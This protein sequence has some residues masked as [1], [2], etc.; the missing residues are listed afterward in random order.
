VP[1]KI[2]KVTSKN[3]S[4]YSLEVNWSKP[5][6]NFSPINDYTVVW[7][8]VYS[9]E[10][11]ED[12]SPE[13]P[14]NITGLTPCTTYT[15][16]VIGYNYVGN[17]KPSDIVTLTTGKD[18][19]GKS[20]NVNVKNVPPYSLQVD[21]RL[22]MDNPC[23]I[24]SYTVIWTNISGGEEEE[25]N[26]TEPP[27]NITGLTACTDYTITVIAYTEKG[28][29]TPSDSVNLTTGNEV[30]GKS[31]NVTIKS[32]TPHSLEVEWNQP[33][34]NACSITSYTVICADSSG[35]AEQK[36]NVTEPPYNIT[37]LT[38]CTDYTITVIAYTEKGPGT[39]S[40]SVNLTTGNEV[41]GKSNNVTIKSITPHSLEVEWNQP[42]D[43]AC[44]I[45]SYTVICADSSGGAEQKGNVTEPPYNIT[46][47]TACTDYT[48]TV[49]A[50]TEKGPGTP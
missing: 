28:P 24:T 11:L 39:P 18:V 40:D 13:P 46:G 47:L 4:P 14:Y 12:I 41:P 45:T 25:G 30:P 16:S 26:V 48:I 1:G 43:N 2:T 33:L 31:N 34:D 22:P 8:N 23:S 15:I 3:V 32:I 10:E 27:Y 49:I 42:L 6:D 20:T 38:A 17:G 50:Y 44:S 5:L 9:G 29:G 21:W 7:T 36:G 37:G 35:G 19:P